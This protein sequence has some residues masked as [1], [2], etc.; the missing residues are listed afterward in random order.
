MSRVVLARLPEPVVKQNGGEDDMSFSRAELDQLLAQAE[1]DPEIMA[2]VRTCMAD[3][4]APSPP[5]TAKRSEPVTIQKAETP[6]DLQQRIDG[7]RAQLARLDEHR[8]ALASA[9]ANIAAYDAQAAIAKGDL[10]TAKAIFTN[11]QAAYG[12]YFAHLR[13]ERY[14]AAPV[15]KAAPPDHRATIMKLVR[16]GDMAGLRT[17]LTTTPGA[18]QQ[19]RDMLPELQ[20]MPRVQ[21]A[22]GEVTKAAP[23]YEKLLRAAFRDRDNAKIRALLRHPEAYALYRKLIGRG[24]L[25]MGIG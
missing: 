25:R 21:H 3:P 22:L 1:A 14:E 8:A 18:D 12:A 6:A 13:G 15:A 7:L 10:T 16:E 4:G 5:A 19:Y 11:D 17:L 23:D 20:G 2:L 24:E 9:N